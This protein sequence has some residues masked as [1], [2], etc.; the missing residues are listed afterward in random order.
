MSC[1]FW[2][3]T[4]L[5]YVHFGSKYKFMIKTLPNVSK[6]IFDKEILK[7]IE[8]NYSEIVPIWI[9]MQTQWM[10]NLYRTFYDYDKFMIIVHLS[11]N[12][13]NF[14]SKNFVKLN[15][16]EYFDQSEIE[17]KEVNIIEISNSLNIPKETARRKVNELET[18]EII[19][20]KKKR[21]IIDRKMWPSIKPE[22]TVK[23]I[24]LFLSILSKM[25]YKEK[26]ISEQ[27]TS[28]EI[29][30][31][32]KN[33]FSYIW[34]LYYEMQ[35]PMLLSFKKIFGDLETMHIQGI[36]LGNQ[37]LNSKI[38]D[39][40]KMS[41]KFYL[42]KFFSSD[43]KVSTGINAMSISDISGIPRAT[44][45]RKLKK[46][47]KEDFLTINNK[48]HYSVT[49]AHIEELAKVQKNTFKSLSMLAALVYNLC[50]NKIN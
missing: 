25:L 16:Q 49:G 8:K 14:Y 39:N 36:C 45:I 21:I 17:I 44:V 31:T 6:Q 7:I 50:L 41:K 10:N 30:I 23:R 19:K 29:T 12:T 11:L 42:E 48:K 46:L 38:M 32:I 3:D 47:V 43:I 4:S 13:F 24:S 15:Y 20:R 2:V 26:M 40:S 28:D 34:K 5:N 9:P 35:M 33:N 27:L 22:E 18:L 1:S 37:A